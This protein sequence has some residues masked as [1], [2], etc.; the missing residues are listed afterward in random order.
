MDYEHKTVQAQDLND[1]LKAEKGSGGRAEGG[2]YGPDIKQIS[3]L[4]IA[5]MRPHY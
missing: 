4:K 5:L 3:I 2:P 1:T